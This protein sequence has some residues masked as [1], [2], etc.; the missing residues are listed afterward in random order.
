MSAS[1]RQK[2][3]RALLSNNSFIATR[4]PK[5]GQTAVVSYTQQ[6]I[7]YYLDNNVYRWRSDN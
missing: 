4:A 3:G 2:L 6:R 7:A 1:L 5:S